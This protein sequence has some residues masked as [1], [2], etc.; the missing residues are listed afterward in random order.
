MK[1]FEDLVFVP[2]RV[3]IKGNEK[4]AEMNFDNGCGVSVVFGET[5]YSD[6]TS[7]YELA[8]LKDGEVCY[9]TEVTDDVLGYLSPEEVSDAMRKVQSI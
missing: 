3:Q 5:F 8:V 9:D 7:T 4:H 2:H 1:T 6:G